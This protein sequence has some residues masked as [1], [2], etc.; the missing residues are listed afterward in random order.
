MAN[1]YYR[2]MQQFAPPGMKYP[3]R[4]NLKS[5]AGFPRGPPFFEPTNQIFRP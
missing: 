5:V 2:T 3:E 1:D 4:Q